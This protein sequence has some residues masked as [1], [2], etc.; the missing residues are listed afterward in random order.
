[1]KCHEFTMQ[2]F[3]M[4]KTNGLCVILGTWRTWTART[5][6]V[7]LELV[8]KSTPPA[9]PSYDSRSCPSCILWEDLLASFLFIPFFSPKGR[10]TGFLLFVSFH[11]WK[12]KI[13]IYIWGN[14]CWR[15]R[16]FA[17][18]KTRQYSCDGILQYSLL[19]TCQRKACL[20]ADLDAHARCFLPASYCLFIAL[21][22]GWLKT[23]DRL[24]TWG[25]GPVFFQ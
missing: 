12:K 9:A 2:E 21:V 22:W 24:R 6:D 23:G 18:E 14:W 13:Y 25:T 20:D 16:R 4:W 1:M 15:L 10:M 5:L 8:P 17:V 11:I 7:F 19:F 3:C